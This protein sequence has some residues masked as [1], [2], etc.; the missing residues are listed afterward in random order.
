MAGFIRVMNNLFIYL[1][2]I[3]LFGSY[4]YQYLHGVL[5]CYLC[6]MQK[7]GMLGVAVAILM[8]FRF[9]V[10][11][12]YYGLAILSALLGR[13]FSLRQI[14]MHLCP[15]FPTYGE[16]VLGLD[17]FVWAFIVFSCSIFACA[18]LTIFYGVAKKREFPPA[19]GFAEKLSFWAIF[20]MAVS[21]FFTTLIE[22]GWS[23]CI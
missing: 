12:Q 8:H 20:L 16:G 5:P 23:G 4:L 10:K 15:E 7:L 1:L 3:V 6:L 22:C 2:F 19:W 13:A 17:L 14:A 18:V 9:G 21:H 11:A